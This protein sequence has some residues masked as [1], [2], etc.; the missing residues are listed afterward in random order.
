MAATKDLKNELA[1][2]I[3]K[4]ITLTEDLNNLEKQIYNFE[5]SYLED[6]YLYGNVIRGWDRFLANNKSTNQKIER[7]NRKFKESE[8]L[9][10]KSSVTSRHN[11]V[12]EYILAT[13]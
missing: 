13:S 9:F 7:R 4:K 10:S 1:D 11:L 6:T 8:R 2:L 12:N 5:S 3:K